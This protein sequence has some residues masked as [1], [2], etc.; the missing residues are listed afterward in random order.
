VIRENDAKHL[1][2][3]LNSVRIPGSRIRTDVRGISHSKIINLAL[4]GGKP[5]QASQNNKEFM[6]I[7]DGVWQRMRMETQGLSLII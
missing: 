2:D 1:L 4:H 7:H 6:I 3:I 5:N